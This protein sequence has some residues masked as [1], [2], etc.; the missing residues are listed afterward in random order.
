MTGRPE[1]ILWID[2]CAAGTGAVL[3]LGGAAWLAPWHGLP[4]ELLRG[5]GA[6]SAVYTL[7]A[8]SLAASSRRSARRVDVLAL[9]NLGWSL[10]C[11]RWA[12]LHAEALTPL[13]L[14]HLLGEAGFVAVLGLGEW[15][16]RQRIA[17][18]HR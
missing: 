6:V 1:R 8:F 16:G 9:A 10:A 5:M 11:L 12:A 18:A 3:L 7:Y 14:V 17:N 4:V 15:R 2:G 13:G